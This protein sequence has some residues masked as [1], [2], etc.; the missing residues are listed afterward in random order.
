M[1]VYSAVEGALGRVGLMA[2]YPRRFIFFTL[3]TGSALLYFKPSAFF[4]SA[5]K[6]YTMG[7]EKESITVDWKAFSVLMG[8]ASVVLI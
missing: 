6:A 2:S 5:G 1:Q 4:D 7:G 3:L 8:G